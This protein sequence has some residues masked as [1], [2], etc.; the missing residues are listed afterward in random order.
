VT[1][2][3]V[4]SVMPPSAAKAYWSSSPSVA[5]C[6]LAS[7]RRSPMPF[8]VRR[9][10]VATPMAVDGV[11]REIAGIREPDADLET[12]EEADGGVELARELRVDDV[13]RAVRRA[14]R[15]HRVR[16][17]LVVQHEPEREALVVGDVGA[18]EREEVVRA[19]SPAGR[20]FASIVRAKG[21]AAEARPGARSPDAATADAATAKQKANE[22]TDLVASGRGV[23]VIRGPERGVPLE[24]GGVR[25]SPEGGRSLSIG[26]SPPQSQ[27][28]HQASPGITGASRT[29]TCRRCWSAPPCRRSC[30]PGRT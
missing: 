19:E 7:M 11:T 12:I 3:L 15:E 25:I 23:G 16:A 26:G 14:R 30:V 17:A 1:S 27:G 28:R 8:S 13:G 10:P 9:P 5:S 6:A 2:L 21:G 29:C 18:V 24:K 22:R 4:G 20:G